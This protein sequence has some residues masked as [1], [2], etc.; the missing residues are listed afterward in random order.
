MNRPAVKRRLLASAGAVAAAA[1]ASVITVRTVRY[2]LNPKARYDAAERRPYGAFE[3]R[4][5]VVGGGFGGYAVVRNLSSRLGR[6]EDVGVMLV[7]GENHLTFWPMVPGIISG[8]VS[9]ED[10]AQPL[11]RAL[12]AAGTASGGPTSRA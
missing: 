3:K 4:V 8:E 5:L 1:L 12:I 9:A 7:S 2:L 6:R 11:R 10:V